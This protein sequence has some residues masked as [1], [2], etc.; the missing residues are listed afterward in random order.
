MQVA[1]SAT[2]RRRPAVSLL[3]SIAFAGVIGG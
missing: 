1:D 2:L 3:A